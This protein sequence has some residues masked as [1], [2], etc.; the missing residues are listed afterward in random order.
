MTTVDIQ[1]GQDKVRDFEVPT[2]EM[3]KLR[4]NS[5]IVIH[6]MIQGTGSD[7]WLK[8]AENGRH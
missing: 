8:D 5:L 3:L 4:L 7:E 1:S 6:E 2:I